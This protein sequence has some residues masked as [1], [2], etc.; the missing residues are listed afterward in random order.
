MYDGEMKPDPSVAETLLISQVGTPSG[1]SQQPKWLSD[2]VNPEKSVTW[3]DTSGLFYLVTGY[4][5][6]C[7]T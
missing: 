2:A 6:E 5:I 3:I 1:K 4:V 7:I